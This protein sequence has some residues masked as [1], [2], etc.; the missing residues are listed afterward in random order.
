MT[1]ALVGTN[2][3][4]RRWHILEKEFDSHTAGDLER[5]CF[6]QRVDEKEKYE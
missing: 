3:N 2:I 4:G 6:E 1:S 5:D